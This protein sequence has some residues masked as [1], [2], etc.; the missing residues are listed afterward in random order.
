MLT[1]QEVG[2]EILGD[3]PK[4]F[5][6][7]TGREFGVK[8]KYLDKLKQHYSGNLIEC[9]S[10]SDTLNMMRVKHIVPLE[11]AVYVVRYDEDFIASLNDSTAIQIKNTN[12]IGTIVCLYENAKHSS[13]VSKYLPEYTVSIDSVNPAFIFKYLR[14]EFSN[15]PD[16]LLK[17]AA[18][19]MSYSAARNMC[20]GLSK[21][22]NLSKIESFTDAEILQTFGYNSSSHEFLMKS[23]VASRNF[24]LCV[25]RLTDYADDLNT[26][27]YAILSLMI[28]FDKLFDNARSQ[29]DFT[30][31][32]K[33][34][35]RTDV[36]N[37]FMQTYNQLKLSR[38]MPSFDIENSMIYLFSLLRFSS[39]PSVEVMR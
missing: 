26:I 37:M 7:F 34:W 20:I 39:I 1:I 13:K 38:S 21:I 14:S 22:S 31:Y 30:R 19:N 32:L 8:C 25:A 27:Y 18:D 5:Y 24:E 11:P 2:T 4:K 6:V 3:K 35:T 23:G 29:S 9:Q 16:R 15:V 33:S 12:V 36:F 17:L 28:E 10:V